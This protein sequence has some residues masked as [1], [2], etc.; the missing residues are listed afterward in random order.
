MGLTVLVE[1][2]FEIIR[3][4]GDSFSVMFEVDP[5]DIILEGFTATFR[6]ATNYGRAWINKNDPNAISGQI[7][8][9]DFLAAETKGKHGKHLWELEIKK[10]N[11]VY[12]IGKGRMEILK[13]IIA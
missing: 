5:A 11:E 12:T 9:F 8:R 7:I 3:Q 2:E 13:Q 1:K 4:E 10:G 6:M